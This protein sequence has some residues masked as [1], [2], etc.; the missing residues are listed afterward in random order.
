MSVSMDTSGLSVPWR[1][2]VGLVNRKG[3]L[4]VITPLRPGVG[5]KLIMLRRG[6]RILSPPKLN[7]LLLVLP[8]PQVRRLK[9]RKILPTTD[10]TRKKITHYRQKK[11]TDYRHGPPLSIFVFRKKRSEEH[12]VF[13]LAYEVTTL[14]VIIEVPVIFLLFGRKLR[15]RDHFAEQFPVFEPT[16]PPAVIFQPRCLFIR[17]SREWNHKSDSEFFS[18]KAKKSQS[19]ATV[20]GFRSTKMN[21]QEY[22]N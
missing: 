5:C 7:I 2:S 13:F 4:L 3:I 15:A 14:K 19:N 11:L 18:E 9:G 21:T 1:G 22:S 6:A 20:A 10:K 12:F 16:K 8:G 17:S